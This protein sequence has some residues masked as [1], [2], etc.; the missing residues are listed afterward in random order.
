MGK[1]C[2]VSFYISSRWHLQILWD[3]CSYH[4]H[5]FSSWGH[6]VWENK[7]LAQ[8]T[9]L[10][11]G[12]DNGKQRNLTPELEF[13][14]TGLLSSLTCQSV[15]LNA[16]TSCPLRASQVPPTRI[17]CIMSFRNLTWRCLIRIGLL[18]SPQPSCPWDRS[19]WVFKDAWREVAT[20]TQ[21]THPCPLTIPQFPGNLPMVTCFPQWAFQMGREW[22]HQLI[23][24]L[25]F[26]F[27]DVP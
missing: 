18:S 14:S 8:N 15:L 25:D 26:W 1:I 2:W 16:L 4:F 17:F 20:S 27:T 24:E 19:S 10:V 23:A 5:S 9:E 21:N 6:Q 12:V 11:R 3:R 7:P 13:F 22:T